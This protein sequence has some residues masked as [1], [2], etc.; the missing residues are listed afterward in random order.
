MIDGSWAITVS[1]RVCGT[2]PPRSTICSKDGIAFLLVPGKTLPRL[3][4]R[5]DRHREQIGLRHAARGMSANQE[6]EPA[7]ASIPSRDLAPVRGRQALSTPAVGS[8]ANDLVT[9]CAKP[10]PRHTRP[11]AADGVTVAVALSGGGFRATLSGLGVLQLLADSG[12]LGNVRYSS[13]VSGGSVAN[14]LFAHHYDELAAEGFSGEAFSRIVVEPCIERMAG[15]SF[16][17]KL[18]GNAWRIV[19]PEDARRGAGGLVCGLVLRRATARGHAGPVSLRL[20]RRQPDDRRPLHPRARD[21]RRLRQRLRRHRHAPAFA[22]PTR[23]RPRPPSRSAFN[24]MHLKNLDLPC[25]NDRP[26]KLQDGGVY[27]NMGLEAIDGLADDELIIAINAGGLFYVRRG[28]GWIPVI[29]DFLR[30]NSILYRQSTALRRREM[31]ERFR[32]WETAAGE[33]TPAP[34]W[35]RRGVLFG[36]TTSFDEGHPACS[37]VGG[38]P[39][40]TTGAHPDA[41]AREDELRPLRPGDVR[42]ARLPRLVADRGDA[43]HLPPRGAAGCP[44]RAGRV[45]DAGGGGHAASPGWWSVRE[46]RRGGGFLAGRGVR[47]RDAEDALG[48]LITV[49]GVAVRRAGGDEEAVTRRERRFDA[50]RFHLECAPRGVEDLFAVM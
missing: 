42:A 50:A 32:A 9:P 35:A 15:S 6:A 1:L 12:L 8:S 29:R 48:D 23:R 21:R 33:G 17:R 20:Q 26:V 36:L 40:G 45:V 2:G 47:R 39:P 27:D 3:Q 4:H 38:R 30:L 7:V 46:T 11:P 22:S 49:G 10:G 34:P 25:G 28:Y 5:I 37:R 41:G 19:G 43:R 24:P 13:S 14:G 16:T 18:L 44:C 31:V